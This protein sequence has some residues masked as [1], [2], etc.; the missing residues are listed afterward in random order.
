VLADALVFEAPASL[1]R[2]DRLDSSGAGFAFA[3]I[4]F[5]ALPRHLFEKTDVVLVSRVTSSQ[6]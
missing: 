3:K 6:H 4:R 5:E 1:Q 2:R